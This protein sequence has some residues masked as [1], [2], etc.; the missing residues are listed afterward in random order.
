V[1]LPCLVLI[2]TY[3]F[4]KWQIGRRAGTLTSEVAKLKAMGIPTT[5]D[6]LYGRAPSPTQNSYSGY[7]EVGKLLIKIQRRSS[8]LDKSLISAFDGHPSDIRDYER[9]LK[10]YQPVFQLAESFIG[11]P[12]FFSKRELELA[13]QFPEYSTMRELAKMYASRANYY[14]ANGQF[15]NAIWDIDREFAIGDHVRQ[16]PVLI[17][18]LVDAAITSIAYGNVQ[19]LLP[20]IQSDPKNLQLL[21]SVLSRHLEVPDTV[22]ELHAEL[23]LSRSAIRQVRRWSD[24]YGSENSPP[25]NL[26]RIVDNATLSDPTVRQMFEAKLVSTYRE[27]FSLLPKDRENFLG[28]SSAFE[29]I[30][31][32]VQK[33]NSLENRMNQILLPVFS[34]APIAY[35]RSQAQK[36]VAL[37]AVR[38]MQLPE[39]QLPSNLSAYGKFGMDPLS[40]KPLGYRKANGKFKVWSV[41]Y[42]RIDE[43]GVP[44]QRGLGVQK[45]DYV[46][47]TM[48]GVK[49]DLPRAIR[50]P[51]ALP[52][53]PPP[54]SPTLQ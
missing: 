17:A 10:E 36:R 25:D 52:G 1:G 28:Q 47:G 21:E 8:T 49:Y 24:L 20:R 44:S 35:A 40:R 41:G 31:Q 46:L 12:K 13:T 37:M 39:D 27:L 26:Q 18:G 29:K 30:D 5:S 32:R 11:R 54:K 51:G 14:T 33:D 45:G 2:G 50:R 7:L 3:A 15:A 22:S 9:A 53:G 34:Q 38:L 16:E 23:I 4:V 43:G 48:S 6:E 19:K 42:N